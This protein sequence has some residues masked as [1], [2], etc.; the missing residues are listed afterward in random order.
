ML[1]I[2]NFTLFRVCC[3]EKRITDRQRPGVLILPGLFNLQ[4]H[5]CQPL[6]E[7]TRLF[8]ILRKV[9]VAISALFFLREEIH[10]ILGVIFKLV[11]FA[12]L[13][14]SEDPR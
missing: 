2:Y 7:I 9:C 12:V 4:C 10:V 14:L 11:C 5:L 3:K 6:P 1:I 13:D 8:Q